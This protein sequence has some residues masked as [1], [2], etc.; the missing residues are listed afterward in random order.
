ME[1]WWNDNGQRKLK[2]SQEK[3]SQCHLVHQKSRMDCPSSKPRLLQ[4]KANYYLR[5][6][7]AI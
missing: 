4:W 6:G 3:L 7:M 2:K 5:Y 1:H